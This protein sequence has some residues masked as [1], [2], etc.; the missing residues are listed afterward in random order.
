MDCNSKEIEIDELISQVSDAV[1]KGRKARKKQ[2]SQDQKDL[3][4][5][6][7]KLNL[8]KMK[9][10]SDNQ[11]MLRQL[12]DQMDEPGIFLPKYRKPVLEDLK[13]RKLR[14]LYNYC[15]KH[16][17]GHSDVVLAN[18]VTC[19][20]QRLN[21]SLIAKSP[22]L[23]GPP[24]TGKSYFPSILCEA[25]TNVG[26]TT[27]LL[28]VTCRWGD[29]GRESLETMLF[30]SDAYYANGMPSTL[31][32]EATLKKNRLILVFVDEIE[33]GLPDCLPSLLKLLD[34]QEP[35]EDTFIKGTW[36]GFQHD[37]RF[38]VFVMLAGNNSK[39]ILSIP[40]LKDRVVLIQLQSYS[41]EQ[42]VEIAVQMAERTFGYNFRNV[43]RRSL[44]RKA[45]KII[46]EHLEITGQ[47]PSYRELSNALE[48]SLIQE[49]F[50][51]LQTEKLFHNVPKKRK[52]G[53]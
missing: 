46:D 51:F 19:L 28:K 30:G 22:L 43:C 48:M 31:F 29:S 42:L 10:N 23:I 16:Y 6:K 18:I 38:K 8:R 53:F 15:K 17:I 40:E 20:S 2:S 44:R 5:L 33:K 1:K 39:T 50:S 26:I 27:L 49:H 37:T 25:L 24:G 11:P 45:H 12:V 7:L 36:P 35:L 41:R 34:P 4:A 14:S 52:I 3:K 32:K 9:A 13:K 47:L 21:G